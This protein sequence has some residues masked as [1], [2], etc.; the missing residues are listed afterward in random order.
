MTKENLEKKEQINTVEDAAKAVRE[1]DLDGA[2]E[3]MK[4]HPD[5]TTDLCFQVFEAYA[6]KN[7]FEEKKRID[8]TGIIQLSMLIDKLL[9]K[10]NHE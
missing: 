1:R 3:F 10:E 8:T 2:I 9:E 6:G 5:D 4:A 7:E